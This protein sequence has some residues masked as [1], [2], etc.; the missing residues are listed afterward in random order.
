[1]VKYALVLLLCLSAWKISAQDILQPPRI[2][3]SD[4]SLS[5][6]LTEL[7]LAVG[8][9]DKD[10]ILSHMNPNM[11]NSFGGDGG[12][13]EF[14]MFWD[15]DDEN[16]K[17]W[18]T[19]ERILRLGGSS[20]TG[21]NNYY[22]IPYVFTD[23]PDTIDAFEHYA[24]IGENVNIR[25]APNIENTEVIGQLSYHI[26]Q[27]LDTTATEEDQNGFRWYH[28]ATMDNS[29]SGYVYGK[30]VVSPIDYRMGF[31]KTEKGWIISLLVA[32]D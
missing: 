2:E 3:I 15:F 32:G 8:K 14:K 19:V 4:H 24:I 1:M 22:T 16:T 11:L 10:F 23:W 26:V 21:E 9:K 28:V 29:L 17:F 7:T 27:H 6:F 18:G 31:E 12:I 13:E 30:Y 20:Y 25:N 5:K